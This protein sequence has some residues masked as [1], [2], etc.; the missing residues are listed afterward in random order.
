MLRQRPELRFLVIGREAELAEEMR[1]LCADL[2][3]LHAVKFC[4]FRPDVLQVLAGCDLLLAPALVE[5]QGRA[6]IEATICRVPVVA[7]DFSGGHS[8]IVRS[9]ETGL[10]V[11]PDDVEQMAEA[12]LDVQRNPIWRR[13]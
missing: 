12:A 4:G 5:G 13:R 7:A 3:I 1:R 6:V 10:L 11:R 8:E 9:G 2:S